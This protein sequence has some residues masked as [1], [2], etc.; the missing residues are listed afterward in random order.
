MQKQILKHRKTLQGE[1]GVGHVSGTYLL[2]GNFLGSRIILSAELNY[3]LA[4]STPSAS[5]PKQ[6]EQPESH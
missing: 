1:Q 6:S 5:T 3:Q 4:R 2:G